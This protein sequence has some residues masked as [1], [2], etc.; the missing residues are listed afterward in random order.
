MTPGG[1]I[2]DCRHLSWNIRDG[3]PAQAGLVQD[4]LMEV[5]T[6]GSL[7]GTALRGHAHLLDPPPAPDAKLQHAKYVH[8]SPVSP[9]C[10]SRRDINGLT[11]P[12]ALLASLHPSI[13]PSAAAFIPPSGPSPPS[14]H[15]FTA[16]TPSPVCAP[17]LVKRCSQPG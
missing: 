14:L 10:G 5:L 4:E 11:G 3:K 8:S 6:C 16:L 15:R 9:A 1:G 17:P 7:P 12:T 2:T 13:P